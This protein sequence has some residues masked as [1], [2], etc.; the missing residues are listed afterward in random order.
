MSILFT[1]FTARPFFIL[2]D[3]WFGWLGFLALLGVMGSLLYNWRAYGKTWGT[4]QWILFIILLVFTP[5][6]SSFLSVEIPIPD[7]IPVPQLTLEI[8]S[9]P[10]MVFS[11]IP[12]M[13]A[14]GLLGPLASVALAIVSGIIVAFWGT[15][16]LMTPIELAFLAILFS[17]ASQQKYR[18]LL[19]R[20][21]RHP[22]VEALC[23]GILYPALFVI[24]SILIVPGTLSVKVDYAITH[25][26][27][28]SLVMIVP[29]L[30][31]GT[32]AELY[33]VAN[34]RWGGQKP[35]L[36]SP[37]ER[38]LEAR[39]S[40]VLTP[41]LVILLLIFM[42]GDWVVAGKAARDM[43]QDSMNASVKVAA[44][45]V[46][47]FL[48]TGQNLILLIASGIDLE[49]STP[50]VLQE[51][52]AKNFRAT[53]FFRN[54]FIL[55]MEKNQIAGFP[56]ADYISLPT[57]PEERVGLDMALNGVPVQVYA[58]PS[59]TLGEAA[60]VSFVASIPSAD[61]SVAGIV[62]GRTDL[63]SNPYTQSILT[64]LMRFS[65][66]DGVG[67]LVDMDGQ[68]LYHS[69]AEWTFS[70]YTGLA[71]NEEDFFYGSA[72][73]GSRM[74]VSSRPTEGR[75]WAAVLMVPA[76]E[77]QVLA[78]NI[79]APLLVMIILLALI[80]AWLLRYS[81]R[82]I[83]SSLT[84]L[85]AEA[86]RISQG[87]LDNALSAGG[88]DEAGRLRDSFEKMRKSLKA[89][90]DELN[91]LLLV[92]QGV[93][94]N[95]EIKDA[96]QPIVDS[97]L[98]VGAS[99]ARIVLAS[100]IVPDIGLDEGFPSRFGAGKE[101][102]LYQYF[103]DQI[104]DLMKNEQ[105][106]QIVL[107]NPVRTPYLSF[108]PDAPRLG[109]MMAVALFHEHM[110]YGVMWV[111][112]VEPHTF[113]EEEVQFLTTLGG[114]A[115]IASA[116]ARLFMTAE[117]E[118]QR[119]AAILASTPDPVLVTD[120]HDCLLLVNAEAWQV[121]GMGIEAGV[122][123]PIEQVIV[124]PEL[125]ELLHDSDDLHDPIELTLA[126]E[127]SFMANASAIRVD[128]QVIGRVC[129]LKDIT[130]FKEL[131]ALK[132]EFVSTVSHDLRSPLTLMRGYATM[133]EMVGELNDQ[134]S[135]YVRKIVMGV[136][137]ISRLVNNLLDLGRIE[138]GVGLQLEMVPLRDIVE[139]VIDS[140]QLQAQQKKVKL[141]AGIAENLPPIIEADQALLQQALHN[142]VENAVKYTPDAG[143]I[144]L[145]VKPGKNKI[146]FSIQDT[147]IGISPVD[148][149]RLFEKFYRSSDR[150]AKKERGS[151]L[152][153]AIVKSIAERH[154]GRIY[155][156]S[157][158]GEGSTFFLE[159]P[160]RN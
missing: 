12:W 158:L 160:L 64:N 155:V 79:A 101:P 34:P 115:S 49:N 65:D 154:G 80:S 130:Q 10:M 132:S 86:E 84:S 159:I 7:A 28:A 128:G 4:D 157:R 25:M 141:Q 96:L 72:P 24:S 81:L 67:L 11:A 150:V 54:L 99:F 123:K 133:L 70:E 116:N 35:W 14:G 100:E 102:D 45:S 106:A 85:T 29:L 32:F 26:G 16:S 40:Y 135:D 44:D 148:Q 98:T 9:L 23:L 74:M 127:R 87:Q 62:V 50:I 69:Q 61:G 38:N 88:V 2:P 92:S 46:P 15:H 136:E 78:I 140:F 143:K 41:A 36:P 66:L 107:T 83:T 59:R 42:V 47:Y 137:S 113:N 124:Q 91:R 58:I 108:G 153:L 97:V 114:Q 3:G 77:A 156:Q 89:R 103:D 119:L 1:I 129:V 6:T 126:D 112:F 39:F 13:L 53:P 48:D 60:Q 31:A 56:A 142:L 104:L 93:A 5:L 75:S 19:F 51:Q 152:G 118:R 20:G 27:S 73:D 90:L 82:V 151:G 105:R 149:P 144:W 134:Q 21:L 22:L 55:D 131:D 110:Y 68:I 125:I 71:M 121:F 57:T 109:S 37:A 17:V 63:V 30:V 147:G 43:L 18:T 111:G 138:A 52:L 117:Y 120:Q 145:R 76:R 139:V 95:L 8:T 94:S 122:G 146:I 33:K